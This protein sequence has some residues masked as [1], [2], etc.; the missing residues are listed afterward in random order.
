MIL[1]FSSDSLEALRSAFHGRRMV[2]T[3]GCFD[4]L[5]VGHLR[6]LTEAAGLGDGLVIGL[7]SDASVKRLKGPERPVNNQNDRAEMLYGLKPVFAVVI[8]AEDTPYKLIAALRP[9]ILVKGGDWAPEQ[10]VGS[11]IVLGEGGQ[12]QS[13]QFVENRS[14]SSIISKIRGAAVHK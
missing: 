1:D 7:N 5:H 13:L 14:T 6:Y 4:I 8:F 10:I 11:D 12:V 2:F 3:N 9:Q